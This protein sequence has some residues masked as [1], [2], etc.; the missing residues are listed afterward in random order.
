[1]LFQPLLSTTTILLYLCRSRY[2][3]NFRIVTSGYLLYTNFV[4][5]INWQFQSIELLNPVYEYHNMARV[6]QTTRR[7]RAKSSTVACRS[8]ISNFIL[9]PSADCGALANCLEHMNIKE[10]A[11]RFYTKR[12]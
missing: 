8:A 2:T 9:L 3:N 10:D 6:R 12:V 1:M 7:E 11:V 4:L 5:D